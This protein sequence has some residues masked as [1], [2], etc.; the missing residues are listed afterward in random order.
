MYNC[1]HDLFLFPYAV[2]R[3][4]NERQHER[5]PDTGDENENEGMRSEHGNL[6]RENGGGSQ[7]AAVLRSRLKDAGK[8]GVSKGLS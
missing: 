2:L 7:I 4:H 1:Y 6:Y 5:S 3:K 8:G